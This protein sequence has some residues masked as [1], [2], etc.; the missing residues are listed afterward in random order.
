METTTDMLAKLADD[1]VAGRVTVIDLTQ[2]LHPGTPVIELPSEFA[3]SPGGFHSP[4]M[5]K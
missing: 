4:I 5:L 1:L 2:P 3:A